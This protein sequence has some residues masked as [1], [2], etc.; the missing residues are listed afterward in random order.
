[1]VVRY[2][3]LVLEGGQLALGDFKERRVSYQMDG[4]AYLAT[5]GPGDMV[6]LHWDWVY[7]LLSPSQMAILEKETIHHLALA[8]QTL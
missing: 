6:S 4:R 1:L 5:P 8:N 2:R 7:D 3:P